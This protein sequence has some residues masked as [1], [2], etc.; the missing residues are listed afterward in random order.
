MNDKVRYLINVINQLIKYLCLILLIVLVI[1]FTY[2]MILFF[3]L[4]LIIFN[5][6]I[7]IIN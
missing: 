4:L 6:Y 7:N 5:E 2:I 3:I 1:Y